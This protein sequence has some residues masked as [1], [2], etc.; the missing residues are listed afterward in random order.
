L[1]KAIDGADVV[2]IPDLFRLSYVSTFTALQG[3]SPRSRNLRGL[4]AAF[5]YGCSL[6]GPLLTSCHIHQALGHWGLWDILLP[7]LKVVSLVTCHDGLGAALARRYRLSVE[8]THIIP[9][10]FKHS[11]KFATQAPTARHYPN[12]FEALREPLSAVPRGH[13]VL[14][15]AGVLGKVYCDWIKA[16]GGIAIDV[17]SAADYWCGY[18]TRPAHETLA[19]QSPRGVRGRIEEL[20]KTNPLVASIVHLRG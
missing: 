16:A 6:E 10:E 3:V 19:Y 15:A 5:D 14:V 20:A 9:P 11:A 18:N 1:Q 17:G 4:V 13:V 2:G 7:Q 12:V 8:T